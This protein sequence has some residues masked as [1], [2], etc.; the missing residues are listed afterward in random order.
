MGYGDEILAAGQAQ[1][2]YEKHGTPVAIIDQQHH[3]RWHPI[4]EGNPA[5]LRPEQWGLGVPAILNAPDARP[6]ILYPF[7]AESGWRFKRD[8]RA[9][10]HIAKIY[11]TEAE[12]DRGFRA[13]RRYGAYILIEPWSKHQNLRWPLERWQALIDARPDL[14]WV[15]H[16]HKDSPTL[17]GV[18]GEAA[19]FRD[20]CGLVDAAQIYIRGE[21]GMLHAAA[22]L[23]ATTIA[24]W[25]GCM[26]WDVLGGYPGEHGVGIQQP[27]CG[28]YKPCKHCAACMAAITVDEVSVAIDQILADERRITG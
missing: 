24:L 20:A 21:S 12:R 15:Q 27:F 23:G 17:R 7:T 16:T 14:T 22:A 9:R 1:R 2:Y 13:Y 6:Y 28:T 3:A 10:D 5:I 18:H 26:D 25:G 19:T 8:F 11:L 4:W